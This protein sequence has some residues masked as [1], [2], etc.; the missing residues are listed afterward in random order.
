MTTQQRTDSLEYLHA[1]I[2]V[3]QPELQPMP[4][5][6]RALVERWIAHE[7]PGALRPRRI[8][9]TRRLRQL[10]RWALLRIISEAME[11]RP[12]PVVVLLGGVAASGKSTLANRLSMLVDEALGRGRTAAIISGDGYFRP[13]VKKG[14]AS[15]I[16]GREIDGEYDNPAATDF[17]RLLQDLHALRSGSAVTIRQRSVRDGQETEKYIDPRSTVVVIIEGLYVLHASVSQFG[18][19]RIGVLTSAGNQMLTRVHRDIHDRGRSPTDVVNKLKRD[20]YQRCFVI[21]TLKNAEAVLYKH[22]YINPDPTI[23]PPEKYEEERRSPRV[24]EILLTSQPP[25]V[26][27]RQFLEIM[28]IEPLRSQTLAHFRSQF[29]EAT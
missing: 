13:R 14:N 8:L 26:E 4:E 27:W 12:G 23:F 3:L 5:A 19:V 25:T 28:G 17:D 18:E 1:M 6:T 2:E 7:L 21:P 15:F 24:L 9:V 22:D 29:P 16:D 20:L 11:P 10:C